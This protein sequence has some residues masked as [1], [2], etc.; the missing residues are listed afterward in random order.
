MLR[1]SVHEYDW[2]PF[3][4]CMFTQDVAVIQK[5]VKW[6]GPMIHNTEQN[7]MAPNVRP[8]AL[9]ANIKSLTSNM[10][11]LHLVMYNK[12]AFQHISEDFYA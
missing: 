1:V 4:Y 7:N 11:E 12:F 5:Y 2:A 8:T 9:R 3:G 10:V 6:V